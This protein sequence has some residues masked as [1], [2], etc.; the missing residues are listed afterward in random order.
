MEE[1]VYM[2][3]QDAYEASLENYKAFLERKKKDINSLIKNATVHGEFNILYDDFMPDQVKEW[4]E[5]QGYE[6]S[7]K[8]LN[9]YEKSW[10]K[11]SWENV[12]IG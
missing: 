4:L 1:N 2:T 9:S 10:W 8:I 12:E 6:V 7:E 5:E 11:I 3:A